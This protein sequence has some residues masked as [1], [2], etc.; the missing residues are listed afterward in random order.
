MSSKQKQE[1]NKEK[2]P[3]IQLQND[4]TVELNN[5]ELSIKEKDKGMIIKQSESDSLADKQDKYYIQVCREKGC[6]GYLK[7]YFSEDYF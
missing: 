4:D 6:E 1:T 5:S 7:F 3:E 2:N